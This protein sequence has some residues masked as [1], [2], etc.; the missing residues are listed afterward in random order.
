[1]LVAA[2]QQIL[3]AWLVVGVVVFGLGLGVRVSLARPSDLW[4]AFWVGFGVLLSFLQLWHLILPIDDR[5]RIAVVTLG[6]IGLVARGTRPWRLALGVLRRH[7]VA[8]T[9]VGGCALWL[10]NLSLGGPRFGDT[11]MYF[12]PTIHWLEAYAIV[13]GLANLFV[14]L[15]HNFSY[16]LYAAVLDAGPF[17]D[18]P[19]HIANGLLLLA[20]FARAALAA[21]RLLRRSAEPLVV[22]VYYFC[23]L[24]ALVELASGGILLTSP[25][26]DFA[27]HVL[28]F[29]LCGELLA[30]V[31]ADPPSRPRCLALVFVAAAAMTLKPSLA[32]LAA[33]VIV[34]GFGSWWR[35]ARPS[36][37][38][39]AR[40]LVFATMVAVI[41]V[42]TWVARNII[43]SGCPLYP[44][45]F[46]A[47]PVEWRTR[48]DAIAWIQGPMEFPLE[49]FV[50]NPQ[51]AYER[52][53][54]LGWADPEF[55]VST[56]LLGAALLLVPLVRVVRWW[57]AK[58]GDVTP[59]I[60]IP[61]VLS[62]A[63]VF[64]NTPMPKYQ[65]A[66]LWVLPV[67]ALIVG[68]AGALADSKRRLRA[69]LVVLVMAGAALP[70]FRSESLL[71]ALSD[72]EPVSP[73]PVELREL[74]SGLSVYVPLVAD[75]CGGG[76]LPCTP[77]PRPRLRLRRPGDLGGGF[78]I[79]DDPQP[80]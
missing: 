22:E 49:T 21:A 31:T 20:L 13:P 62:F 64:V 24:P 51:W 36:M 77:E 60:L 25:T 48:N 42:A 38:A 76:P 15:G 16:F 73:T 52:L 23:I 28:G 54:S 11:W 18:R 69:A 79:D 65:G 33:A 37:A 1:M 10:S 19:W 50:K 4:T 74:P 5:A 80:R 61:P 47:L 46:G 72:F 68:L 35:R 66:V 7:L 2:Q 55:R 78:V 58:S 45:P 17:A 44:S 40:T 9:A 27:V 8:V 56:L 29:V 71:R 43:T 30:L 32:V 6:A 12:V 53:W 67:T 57:R 14:P 63:F 41:P 75:F 70:L 39:L 34:V 26:P 3:V 59:A